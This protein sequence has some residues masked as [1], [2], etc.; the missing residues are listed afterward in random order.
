MKEKKYMRLEDSIYE[1]IIKYPALYWTGDIKTARI[2]VMNHLFFT[3]GNGYAWVDKEGYLVD[4]DHAEGAYFSW[5][6]GWRAT[7]PAYGVLKFEARDLTHLGKAQSWGPDSKYKHITQPVNLYPLE[8]VNLRLPEFVQPD[9]QQGLI[10]FLEYVL[11]LVNDSGYRD[12]SEMSSLKAM[13]YMVRVRGYL[14]EAREVR[15]H[16]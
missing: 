2:V 16:L 8:H 12:F 15:T 11:V 10:E 3:L 14:Q 13:E 7:G 5:P 6:Q 4:M 9:W 1:S